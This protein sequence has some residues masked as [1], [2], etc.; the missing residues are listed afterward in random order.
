MLAGGDDTQRLHAVEESGAKR[1]QPRREHRQALERSTQRALVGKNG[2]AAVAWHRLRL[3]RAVPRPCQHTQ[4]RHLRAEALGL[5][6]QAFARARV[7][8][9]DDNRAL[10]KR[11]AGASAAAALHGRE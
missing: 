10:R 9:D 3:G 11:P 6:H 7:V 1:H 2:C 5:G 4:L 8:A